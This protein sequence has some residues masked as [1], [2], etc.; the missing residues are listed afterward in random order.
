MPTLEVQ[1]NLDLP[2]IDDW[3]ADNSR[4]ITFTVREGGTVRDLQD[5]TIRW[6]LYERP[7]DFSSSTPVL[8]TTDSGVEL[9]RD[10]QFDPSTGQFQIRI[11]EGA[12]ADEWG[13]YW[14]RVVVDPTG[15]TRQSWRGV[16]ELEDA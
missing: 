16:I 5:D 13:K 3:F 8:G 9:I 2:E 7:Y 4:R 15:A 10:P 1:S 12:L 14:Q 6:A 11:R